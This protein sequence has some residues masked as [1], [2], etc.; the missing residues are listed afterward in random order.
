MTARCRI[1][2]DLKGA[3]A[4]EPYPLTTRN[5]GLDKAQGGAQ[6]D[7]RLLVGQASLRCDR[8]R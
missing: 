5:R 6:G 8:G 1:G 2:V 7:R 4:D 3:E